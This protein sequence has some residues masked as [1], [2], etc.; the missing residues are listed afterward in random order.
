MRCTVLL[1]PS[2]GVGAMEGAGASVRGTGDAGTGRR[3]DACSERP[4]PSWSSGWWPEHPGP[5][6][7]G[8]PT[9]PGRKRLGCREWETPHSTR[10]WTVQKDWPRHRCEPH[11][12]G[13]YRRGRCSSPPRARSSGCN[14]PTCPSSLPERPSWASIRASQTSHRAIPVEVDGQKAK[15]RSGI[16]PDRPLCRRESWSCPAMDPPP[17]P[18]GWALLVRLRTGPLRPPA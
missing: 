9:A 8:E 5:A 14:K 12:G 11:A 3:A 17:A 16:R 10:R 1:I 4:L 15:P 7:R 13:E 2:S 18:L 6:P